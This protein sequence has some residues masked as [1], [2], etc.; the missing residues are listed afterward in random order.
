MLWAIKSCPAKQLMG[1]LFLRQRKAKDL[2]G[3][4][5][6][7]LP[8]HFE[9]MLVRRLPRSKAL[10]PLQRTLSMRRMKEHLKM[11]I[12]QGREHHEEADE[13]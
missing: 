8:G 10:W 2:G 13:G 5:K 6:E 11:D 7:P 3:M 1:L 4:A 12:L 9:Q